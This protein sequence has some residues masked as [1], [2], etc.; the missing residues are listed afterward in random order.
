MTFN[1]KSDIKRVKVDKFKKAGE[2]L[3][4]GA[5]LLGSGKVDA[6]IGFFKKAVAVNP[7]LAAAYFDLALAYQQKGDTP[8]IMANL[9]KAIALKPAD[10]EALN[11][12]GHYYNTQK[13]LDLAQSAFEKAIKFNPMLA[14][15]YYNLGVVLMQKGRNAEAL[16]NYKKSMQIF[17]DNSIVLNNI[18]VNHENMGRPLEALKYFHKALKVNPK[19][20]NA[21]CNIGAYWVGINPKKAAE[22]FKK[23]LKAEPN[24]DNAAFN[25]AVCLRMVGQ[26]E[27]AIKLF[28]KALELNPSFSATYG[29]LYHQLREVCAWKKADKLLSDMRSRTDI[30]IMKGELPAETGFVQ[31]VYDDNP[32]RNFKVARAWSKHIA[33]KV[34]PYKKTYSF[35]GRKNKKI[36]VG[37]L[38]NDFK[39]HATAHLMLGLF[40]LHDKKKFDF[41]TYSYGE[42]DR[43]HYRKEIEKLTKF[44]DITTLSFLEAADLIYKDKIDILVDLKG[45]TTNSRL[46]ISALRPVPVQINYLG[47]PGTTGAKLFDYFITDKITTPKTLV[48][49]FSEK[50]IFIPDSYQ[51]NNN[52]QAI[53]KNIVERY[54][55]ALPD[56]KFI[57]CSFNQPY[58]IGPKLFD[59]WMRILKAVPQSILYLLAKSDSQMESLRSEAKKRK[60]DPKRLY[61]G[62]ALAKPSHLARLALCDLALDTFPCNGHTTTSDCLW[63][64]LPV[65]A[66]L[67]KHFASRVSASLLTAVGLP[68]L[69]AHSVKGYEKMAI[70]LAKNPQKLSTIRAKLKAN[71]LTHPLF[72]TQRFTT[73]LEKA[74]TEIWKNYSRDGKPKNIS[75]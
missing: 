7:N 2:L 16:V 23:A 10:Y 29:Q 44:R 26:T 66:I 41:Y 33:E 1:L 11:L 57:F 69:I 37:Y 73:N 47:F 8:K 72:D 4:K 62:I 68:E 59:A 48:P 43:S 28:E 19:N 75:L 54:K 38:S 18:G 12:L 71:R 65:V 20:A 24:M 27:D 50:L 58:K 70:A 3:N 64:G 53:A 46:E 15:G 32:K 14:D 21:L 39:D 49:F 63:A 55:L 51:V 13:K 31:V 45:H 6:A 40:R 52:Q 56:D 34:K 74:Y 60:V 30:D 61:F 67:G 36:R 22:Y 17:P 5:A 35:A 9:K 25:L 42:N